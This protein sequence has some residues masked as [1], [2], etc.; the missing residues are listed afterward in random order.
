MN[1]ELEHSKPGCLMLAW[2]FTCTLDTRKDLDKCL[3]SI[4]AHLDYQINIKYLLSKRT[5]QGKICVNIFRR[6]AI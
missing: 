4:F 1:M 2:I 3:L 6:D 5:I